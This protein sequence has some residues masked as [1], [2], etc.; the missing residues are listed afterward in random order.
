[1]REPFINN[2]KNKNIRN[3]NINRI[4]IHEK[5]KKHNF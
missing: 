4:H 2:K 1:V 3:I 5:T